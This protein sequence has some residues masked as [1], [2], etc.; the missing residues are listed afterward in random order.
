MPGNRLL[1]HARL[2]NENPIPYF[3]T[4]PFLHRL[5]RRFPHLP[6]FFEQKTGVGCVMW[7]VTWNENTENG[8]SLEIGG[9]YFSLNLGGIE[10]K[11]I[12]ISVAGHA[13][14]FEESARIYDETLDTV[15]IAGIY[16]LDD[17]MCRKEA[18]NRILVF[19]PMPKKIVAFLHILNMVFGKFLRE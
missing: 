15:T 2:V 14:L 11:P 17:D 9:R 8:V 12:S 6:D 5:R 7:L 13:V 19:L 4:R 1:P 18:R 10:K 16:R 3:V